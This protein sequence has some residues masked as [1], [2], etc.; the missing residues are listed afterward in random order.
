VSG[1]HTGYLR[2]TDVAMTVIGATGTIESEVDGQRLTL[3]L[4]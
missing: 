4:P 1:Q 2:A 3:N